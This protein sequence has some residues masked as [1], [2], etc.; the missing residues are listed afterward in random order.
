MVTFDIIRIPIFLIKIRT[1]QYA[2]EKIFYTLYKFYQYI[3]TNKIL[4]DYFLILTSTNRN[5]GAAR[6][7]GKGEPRWTSILRWRI[8]VASNHRSMAPSISKFYWLEIE[9]PFSTNHNS[10]M[11]RSRVVT[12]SGLVK[13][14]GLF[15]MTN[16][17]FNIIGAWIENDQKIYTMLTIQKC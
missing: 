1:M 4:N 10:R 5:D 9:H 13:T 15:F 6:R 8:Y 11:Y 14:D 3:A 7:T 16:K 12:K 2:K 17:N